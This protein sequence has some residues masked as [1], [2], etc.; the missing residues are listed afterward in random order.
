MFHIVGINNLFFIFYEV[1]KFAFQPNRAK[2][3]KWYSIR[4]KQLASKLPYDSRLLKLA[5]ATNMDVEEL[6]KFLDS[7]VNRRNFVH[8]HCTSVP[9]LENKSRCH[10]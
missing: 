10:G 3:I 2:Q 7:V 1:L 6:G 9:A 5:K 8:V 4:Y